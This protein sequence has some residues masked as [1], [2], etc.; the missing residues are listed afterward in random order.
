MN[1]PVPQFV[2]SK[3]PIVLCG[4]RYFFSIHALLCSL[5]CKLADTLT[6]VGSSKINRGR[7]DHIYQITLPS[8]PLPSVESSFISADHNAHSTTPLAQPWAEF[9]L[10]RCTVCS[11]RLI[12][13]AGGGAVGISRSHREVPTVRTSVRASLRERPSVNV[14]P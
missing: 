4:S 2:V 9:Y 6:V 10:C 12:A 1:C 7:S 13:V 14:P 3:L 5:W 11:R 8:R